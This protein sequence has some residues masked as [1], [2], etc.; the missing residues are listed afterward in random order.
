MND[1]FGSISSDFLPPGYGEVPGKVIQPMGVSAPM[2]GSDAPTMEAI[3]NPDDYDGIFDI[4]R[5][6]EKIAEREAAKTAKTSSTDVTATT[7]DDDAEKGLFWQNLG[8]MFKKKDRGTG[9]ATES[10]VA[11]A[12]GYCVRKGKH[13]AYV[14]HQYPDGHVYV[15]GPEGAPYTGKTWGANHA[16]AKQ[17]K[18]WYGPCTSPTAGAGGG[19]FL[20]GLLGGGSSTPSS[21][22][23][24]GAAVGAGIG[25]G[26]NQLLPA[27]ASILGPQDVTIYD[28]EAEE[29]VT[30]GGGGS[31]MGMILGGVVVVGLVGVGIYMATRDDDDDDDDYGE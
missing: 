22:V 25:A 5:S 29:V 17:V 8:S 14:Y 21:K 12:A 3:N 2:P 26:I 23:E 4:F 1:N 28:D 9:T 19:S 24:R 31:G 27:L 18:S 11:P 10:A 30:S 7:A 6:D 13:D 20:T 16:G 15:A